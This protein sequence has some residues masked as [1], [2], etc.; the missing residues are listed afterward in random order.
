MFRD[1]SENK[2]NINLVTL[3]LPINTE[4]FRSKEKFYSSCFRWID[5]LSK[6]DAL[7]YEIVD[8]NSDKLV[9]KN[10][11]SQYNILHG[12]LM[13]WPCGQWK[14]MKSFSLSSCCLCHENYFTRWQLFI[15]K[16][17][18]VFNYSILS[19]P[20]LKLWFPICLIRDNRH[21]KRKYTASCINSALINHTMKNINCNWRKVRN[22]FLIVLFSLSSLRFN[23]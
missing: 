9:N 4:I 3:D 21:Y 11:S 7:V 13:Y 17:F 16:A 23:L 22:T 14:A 6:F 15:K 1:C 8:S 19:W 10:S 12:K 5:Y 2:C 18:N 20:A